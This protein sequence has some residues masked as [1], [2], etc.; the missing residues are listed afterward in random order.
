MAPSRSG[1]ILLC[2]HDGMI[3]EV[4]HEGGQPHANARVGQPLA[5][6]VS[7]ECFSKAFDFLAALRRDESAYDWEVTIETNG[8][9]EPYRL[10]GAVI[11]AGLAVA[12]IPADRDGDLL[13][14]D[15]ARLNS[16]HVTL[17]RRL[18]K[19]RSARPASGAIYESMS[20]LNSE[21]VNTQRQLAK[22][23][24][25]LTAAND[26]KN[27]LFGV[28]AHD[29]RTPLSVI[30]GYSEI[31]DMLLAPDS[32]PRLRKYVGNIHQSIRYMLALIEDVLSLSAIESGHLALNRQPCDLT[33]L[34]QRVAAL[35]SVLGEQKSITILFPPVPPVWA[36]VD[37]LKIEQVMTNLLSNAVKFSHSNSSITLAVSAGKDADGHPQARIDVTDTG[38]GMPPERLETLF[39]PFRKGVT[40]T[41]GEASIGLGLYICAK[42]IEAHGGSIHV[43]STSGLGTTVT[44]LLP[45]DG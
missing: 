26:Q 38:I 41:A 30:S 1:L 35:T 29:L 11:E 31:L 27:R 16:D 43:T 12:A 44:V 34:M 36:A 3:T 5:A 37:A 8:R 23:N 14:Q 13:I 15:L 17:L 24:A 20:E 10:S 18:L 42:M 21:L 28:L 33:E 39:H 7:R 9:L 19:E 6:V 40:G 45:A 32:D 22:A 4:L 25:R 2:D